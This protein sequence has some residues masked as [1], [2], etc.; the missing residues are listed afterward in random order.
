VTGFDNATTAQLPEFRPGT[1]SVVVD[2]INDTMAQGN[3]ER[4]ALDNQIEKE[5]LA[6]LKNS[7]VMLLLN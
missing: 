6:A 4:Q 7:N 1:G 2:G 3:K 5:N